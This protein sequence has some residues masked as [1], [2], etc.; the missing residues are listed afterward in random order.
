ME[1][2]KRKKKTKNEIIKNKHEVYTIRH[3][4]KELDR[5]TN[6]IVEVLTNLLSKN[7]DMRKFELWIHENIKMYFDNKESKYHK[8]LEAY[9]IKIKYKNLQE[10]GFSSDCVYAIVAKE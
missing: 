3:T 1:E 9:K 2:K 7:A 10:D 4:Y 5:I 8:E 6:E